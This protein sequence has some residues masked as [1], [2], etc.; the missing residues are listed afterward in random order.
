MGHGAESK[1]YRYP[2]I[3]LTVSD[4]VKAGGGYDTFAAWEHR[5]ATDRSIMEIV[6]D[7]LAFWSTGDHLLKEAPCSIWFTTEYDRVRA[8][9]PVT[10]VTCL[11]PGLDI[12]LDWF[13]AYTNADCGGNGDERPFLDPMQKT[14]PNHY[15]SDEDLRLA[16]LIAEEI[17][18]ILAATL[19]NRYRFRRA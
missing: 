5:K 15:W 12:D 3:S 7:A 11:T 6:E 10:N 2:N 1:L 18:M 19:Y 4:I 9:W 16:E 14:C 8:K 17:P 13:Y